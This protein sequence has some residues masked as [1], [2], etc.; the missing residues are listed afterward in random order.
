[1]IYFAIYVKA[2]DEYNAVGPFLKRT[3]SV[4]NQFCLV[5]QKIVFYTSEI[6]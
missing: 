4:C 1:M 3:K 6:L 2:I 5:I